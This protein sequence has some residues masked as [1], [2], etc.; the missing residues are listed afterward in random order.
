M[1]PNKRARSS[2]IDEPLDAQISRAIRRLDQITWLLIT[3]FAAILM[4]MFT[5]VWA[6]G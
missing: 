5:I 3:I 4:L 6:Y 2:D 1:G